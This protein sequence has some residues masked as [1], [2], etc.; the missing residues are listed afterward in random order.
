MIIKAK[1]VYCQSK[2]YVLS[3]QRLPNK[4]Y[5]F[6]A[7][8]QITIIPSNDW[9]H[10]I[11]QYYQTILSLS[12]AC[13]LNDWF[14]QAHP[15]SP[16]H[17]LVCQPVGWSARVSQSVSQSVYQSICQSVVDL[18]ICLFVCLSVTQSVCLTNSF[19]VCVSMWLWVCKD[20]YTVESLA[21]TVDGYSHSQ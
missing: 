14:T 1:I 13:P 2:D 3:K 4:Y 15:L 10:I 5:Q 7:Q 16:I 6:C 21:R 8:V 19:I 18:S 12:L 20:I 11:T 17:L 9:C